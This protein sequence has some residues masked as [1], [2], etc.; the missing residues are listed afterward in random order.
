[1]PATSRAAG[2]QEELVCTK[3][4]GVVAFH[5]RV[6][7]EAARRFCEK[8][9]TSCRDKRV[10]RDGESFHITVLSPNDAN[11]VKSKDLAKHF[12]KV[13]ARD[14]FFLGVGT[15]N[16][17]YFCVVESPLIQKIRKSFGLTRKDLHITLGFQVSDCHEVCKDART[18]MEPLGTDR[19]ALASA[20]KSYVEVGDL[21]ESMA[22]LTLAASCFETQKEIKLLD[23]V[24]AKL[25]GQTESFDDVISLCEK[26]THDAELGFY[27]AYL[28]G[29][30]LM[31]LQKFSEAASVLDKALAQ[32]SEQHPEAL[33]KKIEDVAKACHDKAEDRAL[34]FKFPR[35]H[36]IF[37]AGGNAVTRD[38]LLLDPLDAASYLNRPVFCEEKIDGANLG[39]WLDTDYTV[40]CQNRSHFVTGESGTQWRGLDQWINENQ[41]TLCQ[42]LEPRKHILF[43]EWMYAKHSLEYDKLPSFFVAFDLYDI[44]QKKFFSRR[45]L[46]NIL[47]GTQIAVVPMILDGQVASLDNF[48]DM[49][50]TAS[51]FKSNGTPVEGVYIR[52]DDEAGMWLERRCKL[53]RPDFIQGIETH[54][55]S[56]NLVRNKVDI[57]FSYTYA[58]MICE[59]RDRLNA[60]AAPEPTQNEEFPFSVGAYTEPRSVVVGTNGTQL[61]RNFSFVSDALALSSIPK[62]K[63]QCLGMGVDLIVTL[64][65]EERLP[66]EWFA[67]APCSNLYAPIPNYEPPS[68]PDMDAI[69][70]AV[71]RAK[72]A[73]A[74]GPFRVM[75]HCGG[76][77]GRAGTVAACLLLRDAILRDVV[78]VSASAEDVGS[79]S[80]VIAFLRRLRPGCVE[81]ERQEVFIRQYADRL[82]ALKAE[83]GADAEQVDAVADGVQALSHW[84]Q[85]ST[86]Q[87][88][89][90]PSKPAGAAA[91]GS[92]KRSPRNAA[93]RAAN[94]DKLK[95]RVLML[96]GLPGSGKSTLSTR[97]VA[98]SGGKVA[99]TRVNQDDQ[100]RANVQ[101]AVSAWCKRSLSDASQR[102]VLDMCNMDVVQRGKW[103]ETL[104]EA[105]PALFKATPGRSD[106]LMALHLDVAPE[107]CKARLRARTDHPTIKGDGARIIDSFAKTAAPPTP[108]EG[109]GR[110]LVVRND[111]ELEAVLARLL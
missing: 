5:G 67:N 59:V 88:A 111:D 101:S 61:P 68:A 65:D 64:T 90:A 22:I 7:D 109:F 66:A 29:F 94:D 106:A 15:V 30:A 54:W 76:G 26:H 73:K 49:L 82:W 31:K 34:I 10:D 12:G 63:E 20:L 8:I 9:P 87:A 99:W 24:R 19:E 97:L 70:L 98:E 35:T 21:H 11:V 44:A 46:Y 57:D 83:A 37:D 43:G 104:R 13:T 36:H 16:G 60:A 17:V 27:A 79:S 3:L 78:P 50:E 100:G 1:M 38:D 40:R 62:T 52:V 74:N 6:V 86:G 93:K 48:K 92:R 85:D 18:L 77:K 69:A 23:I 84:H 110:V 25:A 32:K 91:G 58:D 55:M 107:Q 28:M 71:D 53:V 4:R 96:C 47:A 105:Q 80:G 89:A 51:T 81:T 41:A 75:V 42:L 39:I 103:L 14:I 2:A 95:P 45:R 56:K 102:L 33:I 108:A 72:A